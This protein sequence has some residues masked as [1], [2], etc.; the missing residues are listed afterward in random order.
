MNRPTALRH[1]IV[2][3]LKSLTVCDVEVLEAFPGGYK[4]QVIAEGYA[5]KTIPERIDII[6]EL[7][8]QNAPKLVE[9]IFISFVPL[10]PKK[11]DTEFGDGTGRSLKS[12]Q[13]I[14]AAKTPE[15]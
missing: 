10:I 2:Q 14:K 12:A 15:L 8:D 9:D 5:T 11:M 7:M 1:L 13:D 6:M 4:I 3:A